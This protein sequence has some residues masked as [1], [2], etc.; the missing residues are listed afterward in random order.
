MRVQSENQNALKCEILTSN[1]S[2]LFKE[3]QNTEQR[4]SLPPVQ[5]SY[6][7][8]PAPNVVHPY[9]NLSIPGSSRSNVTTEEEKKVCNH[10]S[11]NTIPKLVIKLK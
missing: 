3:M 5:N 6:G 9:E 8:C 7:A 11:S 10:G 1:F 2:T 4:I